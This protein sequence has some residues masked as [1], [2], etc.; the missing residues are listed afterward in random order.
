[1]KNDFQQRPNRVPWPPV[2]YVG[3]VVTAVGLQRIWPLGWSAA[4]PMQWLAPVGW[5]TA[6]AGLLIDVAAMW[7]MRRAR[8]NILPHR[9]ADR[10]VTDGVFAFSKNPIYLGNTLLLFG[11]GMAFAS[12]WLLAG[13]VV[14]AVLVDRL[15]IRREERHLAAR[16]GKAYADYARQVGRWFGRRRV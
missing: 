9:G 5:A 6:V 16:F 11:V 7:A 10:L 15:A 8:T 3:V 14:A 2:I 12:I 1:M 13:A 4:F